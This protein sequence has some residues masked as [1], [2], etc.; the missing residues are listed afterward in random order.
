[1]P[2]CKCKVKVCDDCEVCRRCQCT[3]NG[4]QTLAS[5]NLKRGRPATQVV[6]ASI[7]QTVRESTR[8]A[9]KRAKVVIAQQEEVSYPDSQHTATVET[10]GGNIMKTVKDVWSAY[11]WTLS[12]LKN[13]PSQN[14][15]ES[16]ATIMDTN[17]KGWYTMTKS[18]VSGAV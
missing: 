18:V 13:L 11:G 4:P 3:C 15:R 17:P 12:T 5:L 16:D 2:S 9:A 1:M 10:L 6:V 14:L 8:P 7:Q